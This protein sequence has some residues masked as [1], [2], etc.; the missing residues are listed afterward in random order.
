MQSWHITIYCHLS[1]CTSGHSVLLS[2]LFGVV[3]SFKSNML[4]WQSSSV[5]S[6]TISIWR[7][8]YSA[9]YVHM[10]SIRQPLSPLQPVNGTGKLLVQWPP[11]LLLS[12]SSSA[13][14]LTN[15]DIS[16]IV[17]EAVWNLLPPTD[18]GSTDVY[19]QNNFHNHISL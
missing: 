1:M 2:L 9:I 17:T 7:D 19:A 3:I 5:Y 8:G 13:S 16:W 15:I 6:S 10:W 11:S 18:G 12:G 14:V 4:H